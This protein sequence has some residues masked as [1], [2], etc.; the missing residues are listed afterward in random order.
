M[1]RQRLDRVMLAVVMTAAAT[2]AHGQ[3]PPQPRSHING[4]LEFIGAEIPLGSVVR[5]APFSG[6]G[7]TTVSQTLGDGTRIERRVTAKLYRDSDGRIRREQTVLGL[8]ALKP[9]ADGQPI[10]TITDP[11]ASMTYVLDP[12]TRTARRTRAVRN[13]SE[14]NAADVEKLGAA[15]GQMVE[16]LHAG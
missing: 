2:A 10:V 15:A 4:T 9:S 11:V 14:H 6:E 13:R 3:P 7:V 1:T 12:A 8:D 16:R 5:G